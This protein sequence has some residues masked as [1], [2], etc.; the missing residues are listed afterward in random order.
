MREELNRGS[1]WGAHEGGKGAHVGSSLGRKRGS[2][3]ELIRKGNG[4]IWRAHEIG[5][6][7]FMRSLF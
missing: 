4:L 5:K 6:G 2:C 7:I 1:L 3:R